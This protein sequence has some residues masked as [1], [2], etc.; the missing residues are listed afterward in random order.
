ME[1][2]FRY[3]DPPPTVQ[4]TPP[5]AAT[6]VE[7]ATNR[8]DFRGMPL[9]ERKLVKQDLGGDDYGNQSMNSRYSQTTR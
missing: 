8:K 4:Y 2:N 7:I 3:S 1:N 6:Y 5:G 9:I